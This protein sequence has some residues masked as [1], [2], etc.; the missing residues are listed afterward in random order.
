MAVTSSYT[1]LLANIADWLSRSDL[2]SQIPVFVQ[3]WEERFYRQPK[4]YGKWLEADLTT[5][6]VPFTTSGVTVPT[7]YLG[8]RVFRLVGQPTPL[9]PLSLEIMYTRYPPSG[10]ASGVPKYVA[11][12]RTVFVFGPVPNGTFTLAG[13]YYAKPAPL[14]SYTTGGADA[15]AH[16]LILNAPDLLLYGALLEAQTLL[17]TDER[18][19]MWVEAYKKAEAD[20][21]ELMKSLNFSGGSPQVVVS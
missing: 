13:T 14:R 3:N 8:A 1:T 4:N 9:I 17:Q 11:R 18:V 5:A 7:D 10:G 12:D 6:T 19:P 21:R 2:T 20:Y 15:V 16:F